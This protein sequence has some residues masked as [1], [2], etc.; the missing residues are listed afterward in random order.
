MKS[1]AFLP[2][3]MSGLYAPPFPMAAFMAMMH[4]TDEGRDG[5]PNLPPPTSTPISACSN[6]GSNA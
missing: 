5:C 3:F 6:E 4:Q 2:M 1:M